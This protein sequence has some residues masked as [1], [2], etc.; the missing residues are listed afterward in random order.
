[1][2]KALDNYLEVNVDVKAL[3]LLPQS[4]TNDPVSGSLSDQEF[5]NKHRV[6][7]E[8]A[9]IKSTI[10]YKLHNKLSL[11]KNEKKYLKLW[12]TSA[13]E[14]QSLVTGENLMAPQRPSALKI[15][16]MTAEDFYALAT[17]PGV[18]FDRNTH[19]NFA[20]NDLVLEMAHFVDRDTIKRVELKMLE[21]KLRSEF[22]LGE[23]FGLVEKRNKEL[24][25]LHQELEEAQWRLAAKI[26]QREETAIKDMLW[27][28]RGIDK[29]DKVFLELDRKSFDDFF[30]IANSFDNRTTLLEN[31]I[32][33]KE[34]EF[35]RRVN[36]PTKA[37][38]NSDE[39]LYRSF[40][41]PR[42]KARQSLVS[43]MFVSD[44]FGV[45]K[46]KT[47]STLTT[48]E[49]HMLVESLCVRLNLFNQTYPAFVPQ[50][51]K[52]IMEHD[53]LGS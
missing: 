5:L 19:K 41:G 28:G 38:N 24:D 36:L 32:C 43:K 48:A 37:L 15:S 44:E 50:V 47:Y 27:V 45:E 9:L 2:S 10:V 1:M 40:D 51:V 18:K 7:A 22:G 31:W 14:S 4:A 34:E 11:S 49:L 29:F 25:Y 52:A 26:D 53:N 33:R 6:W 42:K 30:N 23:N 16:D 20:L 12:V 8:S 39:I 3:G 17:I 21:S 46:T 13:R 35:K